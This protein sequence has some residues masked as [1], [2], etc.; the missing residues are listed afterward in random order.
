MWKAPQANRRCAGA[1]PLRVLLLGH[2]LPKTLG[3][4]FQVEEGIFGNPN[5]IQHLPSGCGGMLSFEGAIIFL[6]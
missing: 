5:T 2:Q 4:V 6:F 3:P 1:G